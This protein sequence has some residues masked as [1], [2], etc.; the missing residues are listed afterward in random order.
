MST[1]TSSN[2]DEITADMPAVVTLKGDGITIR[3]TAEWFSG[4]VI[5]AVDGHEGTVT[6][7]HRDMHELNNALYF[8]NHVANSAGG[9]SPGGSGG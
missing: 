3:L 7:D 1:I 6:L 5:V 2:R 8:L 9:M 4:K